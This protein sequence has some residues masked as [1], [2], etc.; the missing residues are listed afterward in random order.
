MANVAVPGR[1][2]HCQAV[3]PVQTG[4]GRTRRYCDATCHSAARRIRTPPAPGPCQLKAGQVGCTANST[5]RWHD[6][7]GAVLARTCNSHRE[8]AGAL[9]RA[10]V[11]YSLDRWLP[12]AVTWSPPVGR[13]TGP[14]HQLQVTLAE[15]H[16]PIW[17]RLQLRSA[18]S[19]AQLHEAIQVAF[20]WQGYHLHVFEAG[21]HRYGHE[22]QDERA[23]SLAQVLPDSGGRAG[24][25]YDFGDCWDHRIEVEKV[26]ARPRA[27]AVYPRCT[28]GQRAGPPEDCGGPGAYE[29]A[30]RAL[31]SRKGWR[32]RWARHA[33]GGS[34]WDAEAL[35]LEQVNGE[36]AALS[37]G[38]SAASP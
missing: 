23:V 35:D 26:I 8:L 3:L 13:L 20:G 21:G 11:P 28:A 12:A 5:G 34:R 4:T 30:V 18:A 29:E 1:C 25:R 31:R 37:T 7:D 2:A 24:Y 32:Y 17:R 22:G 38:V 33:L 19:L 6:I 36:L 14:V 16:P 10:E 9:L 15:V 27:Q